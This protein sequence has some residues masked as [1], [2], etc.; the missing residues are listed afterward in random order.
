MCTK[1]AQ[2][3]RTEARDQVPGGKYEGFVGLSDDFVTVLSVSPMI[4]NVNMY[5]IKCVGLAQV[6]AI[7]AI[8]RSKACQN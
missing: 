6:S 8:F 2:C 7:L 4:C 3:A 5:N 1:L